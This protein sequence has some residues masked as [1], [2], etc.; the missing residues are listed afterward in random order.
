MKSF[1]IAITGGSGSGK[2]YLAKQLIQKYGDDK[3]NLIEVDSY[4]RDL[5]HLTMSERDKNNFDHPDAFDFKLLYNDIQKLK[6]LDSVDIPTYDYKTH[7]RKKNKLTIKKTNIIILEGIFSIYNRNIRNLMNLKIFLDICE[8]TRIERRIIRDKKSRARTEES[9]LKQY[10]NTVK[11]M[12]EKFVK[13]LKKHSDLI[14]KDND[15]NCNE[16]NILNNYIN[17][18]LNI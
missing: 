4:Y 5:K 13:P 9:I 8:K 10:N 2:S 14:I 15:I 17:S 1:Y 12:Y 6:N 18:I 7:T 3:I 11:P 16:I